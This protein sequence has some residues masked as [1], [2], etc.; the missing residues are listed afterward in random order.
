MLFRSKQ[1]QEA[2]NIKKY[3]K[4]I[5][6]KQLLL[7]F[8]INNI[9][10]NN[11]NISESEFTNYFDNSINNNKLFSNESQI[12]YNIPK[13][14]QIMSNKKKI[15]IINTILSNYSLKI[16]SNKKKSNGYNLQILNNIDEIIK[17]KMLFTHYDFYDSNKIFNCNK[18]DLIELY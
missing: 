7:D 16:C 5:L 3:N 12:F 8:N 15:C 18:C 14:N 10:D 11:Y 17:S 4:L 2:E 1:N 13:T 9:F 6:I